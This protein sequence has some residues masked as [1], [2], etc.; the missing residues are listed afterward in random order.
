VIRVE[1]LTCAIGAELS[2]VSLGDASRD[3]GLFGEIRALLL[4]HK[5]LF[6][7]TRKSPAPSTSRSRAA[8]ASWR[9]TR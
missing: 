1:P 8:S 6:F 9:T 5:V 2:G 4:A 3:A 7:R